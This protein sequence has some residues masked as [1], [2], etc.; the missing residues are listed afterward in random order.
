MQNEEL[1][2]LYYKTGA[3]LMLHESAKTLNDYSGGTRP[4]IL[5][6]RYFCDV[7]MCPT[8]L[9]CISDNMFDI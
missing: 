7:L 2:L 3:G 6:G 9:F 5:I 1:E 4:I 8:R